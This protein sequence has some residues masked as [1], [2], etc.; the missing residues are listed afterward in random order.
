MEILSHSLHFFCIIWNDHPKTSE[1]N[2]RFVQI[3]QSVTRRELLIELQNVQNIYSTWL[4]VV[5]SGPTHTSSGLSSHLHQWNT[6]QTQ[7]CLH[8][9]MPCIHAFLSNLFRVRT[10]DK[11]CAKQLVVVRWQL[12]ILLCKSEWL[13]PW[14]HITWPMTPVDADAETFFILDCRTVMHGAFQNDFNQI[15]DVNWDTCLRLSSI[16]WSIV[17]Q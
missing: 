4:T 13:L 7:Q 14:T 10:A 3:H 15:I 2:V 9:C 8:G 6:L 1:T 16:M 17:A 11:L 12:R 5:L